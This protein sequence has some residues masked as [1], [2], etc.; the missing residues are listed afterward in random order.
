MKSSEWACRRHAHCFEGNSLRGKA[1][2][3]APR[4]RDDSAV[5]VRWA[6][7]NLVNEG[8]DGA[9]IFVDVTKGLFLCHIAMNVMKVC[10][11]E[12]KTSVNVINITF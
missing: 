12:F 3:P 1:L 11:T 7:W 2:R 8:A 9:L 10:R 6:E 4:F 5:R